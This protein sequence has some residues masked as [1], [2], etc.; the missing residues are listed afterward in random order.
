M[1]EILEGTVELHMEGHLR[2]NDISAADFGALVTDF[3][4]LVNSRVDDKELRDRIMSL[5]VSVVGIR[6]GSAIAIFAPTPM[7][8]V[9]Q[10]VTET[11]ND[12]VSGQTANWSGRSQRVYYKITDLAEKLGVRPRLVVNWRG[13]VAQTSLAPLVAPPQLFELRGTTTLYG[14]VIRLGGKKPKVDIEPLGY[15]RM[16]HAA[17][18]ASIV[19]ELEQSE[20][21]YTLVALTGEAQWD[22][23]TLE[24]S[25]FHVQSW[26]AFSPPGPADGMAQLRDRFGKY[27]DDIDDVTAWLAELRGEEFE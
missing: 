23:E 12:I 14:K 17:A 24:I 21:L 11:I 15:S 25:K 1:A 7:E 6:E 27:F 9:L 3:E 22:L 19:K 10:V 2:P 16:V 5:K 13:Q 4:K 26:K 20:S 8:T 18:E